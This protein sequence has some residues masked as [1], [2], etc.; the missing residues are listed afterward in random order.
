MARNAERRTQ[1]YFETLQQ[2]AIA[3]QTSLQQAV[4]VSVGAIQ[5]LMERDPRTRATEVRRIESGSSWE[6]TSESDYSS[7]RV[8]RKRVLGVDKMGAQE[9]QQFWQ[10]VRAGRIP[11]PGQPGHTEA[12]Q[13]ALNR[14][15]A[16]LKKERAATPV[17]TPG[18]PEVYRVPTPGPTVPVPISVV[19]RP[20]EVK[21]A[22]P[23]PRAAQPESRTL[24]YG[25]T[26]SREDGNVR[27]IARNEGSTRVPLGSQDTTVRAETFGR[28]LGNLRTSTPEE[29]PMPRPGTTVHNL[30]QTTQGLSLTSGGAKPGKDQSWLKPPTVGGLGDD[31]IL[32]L[33]DEAEN[34]QRRQP[35]WVMWVKALR[36]VAERALSE[37]LSQYDKWSEVWGEIPTVTHR[38]V[39]SDGSEPVED[40]GTQL[41]RTN[42][43]TGVTLNSTMP[44]FKR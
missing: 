13:G 42:E 35:S 1:E 16:R 26:G 44:T 29:P 8:S 34:F 30:P 12:Y 39:V 20:E 14:T 31:N 19:P 40:T 4:A 11:S 36:L 24:I 5:A 10:G 23:G 2:G 18:R 27:R 9:D 32:Q 15:N 43:R 41:R 38:R 6:T 17:A 25:V 33:C 22:T 7:R 21:A 3:T 37:Y 28:P